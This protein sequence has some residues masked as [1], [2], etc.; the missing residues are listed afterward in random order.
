MKPYFL[1]PVIKSNYQYFCLGFQTIKAFTTV[2]I[3]ILKL[4]VYH[5]SCCQTIQRTLRVRER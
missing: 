4:D 1:M 3:I 2:N 5:L